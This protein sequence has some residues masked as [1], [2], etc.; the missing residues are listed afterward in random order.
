[1]R[2]KSLIVLLFV[3]LL[4]IVFTQNTDKVDFVFFWTSFKISKLVI[5]LGASVVAFIA[6]V[7]VGRPK[8]I[9]RMSGGTSENHFEKR[10]PGS[11]SDHDKDYI[12]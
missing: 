7:L 9:K 4:T 3:I 12:N 6:G 2:I 8:R 1:M 10:S 5:M 11:L